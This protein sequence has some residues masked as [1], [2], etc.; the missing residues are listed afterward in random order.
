MFESFGKES[1]DPLAFGGKETESDERSLFIGS[2][3]ESTEL[4]HVVEGVIESRMVGC[5][6]ER[7]KQ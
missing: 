2:E 7:D 1:Q 6:G 4:E 3:D 5:E